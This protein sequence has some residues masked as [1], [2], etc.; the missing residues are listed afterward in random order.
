[1]TRVHIVG[2]VVGFFLVALAINYFTLYENFTMFTITD[3]DGKETKVQGSKLRVDPDSTAPTASTAPTVS[4]ASTAST[5]S[6]TTPNLEQGKSLKETVDKLLGSPKL[7]AGKTAVPTVSPNALGGAPVLG[8][9][10]APLLS[11]T[12][13]LA[14]VIPAN[15]I[16]APVKDSE[17]DK[18]NHKI[19]NYN[20][21]GD[22]QQATAIERRERR[23]TRTVESD[24]KKPSGGCDS[25]CLLQGADYSGEGDDSSTPYGQGQQSAKGVNA[26]PYPIDMNNYIRKDKIP[27]YACSLK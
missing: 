17:K 16:A 13:I 5:A 27:C 26:E 21:D 12:P 2:V 4:T 24:C 6:G 23:E 7:D 18:Q 20:L 15:F 25:P 10:S 22:S 1:M 14:T 19:S 3:K 9:A 11:G 8:A